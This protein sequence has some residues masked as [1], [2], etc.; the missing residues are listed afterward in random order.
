METS[1][2]HLAVLPVMA[3]FFIMG[4]VDIVGVATSY[5]KADFSGMTDS[6]AGMLSLSC[7]FWFLVL[8]VPTGLLM[9]RIGRK[10]TVLASFVITLI[11]MILPVVW[12]DFAGIMTAFALLGI[13]NTILQVSLNPLVTDVIAQDKVTGTLT[14]GQFVKAVSSFLGPV[15]AAVCAGSAFGWKAIFPVYAIVTLAAALWLYFTPVG[16]AAKAAGTAPSIGKTL[17]LFKDRYVLMFF[18]GILVLVGMDVGMG[19]TIPKLLQE[20]CGLSLEKAGMGNSAYFFARTVCA[21]VGGLLLMKVPERRFYPASVAV[22][23]CGLAVLLFS[24]SLA[25][26]IVGIVMFGA[27]FANLFSI[28]F[29]LS[30]KRVPDKADEVS[31]LL[32]MGVSGGAVIPPVLGFF[33]DAFGTQNAAVLVIMAAGIYLLLLSLMV[34]SVRKA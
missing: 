6:M 31:S 19:V 5:V 13:G 27:G 9:G 22:A 32:I 24:G 12:Y 18:I 30:L 33:T 1:K 26:I 25:W 4:F 8:S 15:L 3:G 21:F 10:T 29:S 7:F 11:A 20:R 14:L 2:K 16:S 23:L 17:A 28:I 34:R